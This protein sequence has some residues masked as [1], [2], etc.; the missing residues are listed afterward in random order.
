MFVSLLVVF[1][2]SIRISYQTGYYDGYAVSNKSDT[3]L[4]D[5][6]KKVNIQ[7]SYV[8]QNIGYNAG[9]QHE[10]AFIQETMSRLCTGQANVNYA[11]S[12]SYYSIKCFIS[13]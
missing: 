5:V 1:F 8:Q 2:C 9:V 10:S 4:V 6:L 7:N 12:T 11:S 13:K 3:N